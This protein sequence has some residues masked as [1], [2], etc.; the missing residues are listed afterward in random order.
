MAGI[1]YRRARG[2]K[3]RR[4]HMVAYTVTFRDTATGKAIQYEVWAYSEPLANIKA[5]A[6]AEQAGYKSTGLVLVS[7]QEA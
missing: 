1:Q 7:I 6:A 3:I 5:L 4:R 2:S